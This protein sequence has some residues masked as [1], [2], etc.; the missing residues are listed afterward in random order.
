[1]ITGPTGAGKT[2]TFHYLIDLINS[3]RRAKI[4]TIEDPIEYTQ[5]SKRSVI[6]QQE[7]LTDVRDFKSA[8]THVLRQ[9]PDVIGIG[10]MRDPETIFTA[11]VAAETGHLV[12]ATLHTPDTIQVVERIVSAFSEGQHAM[13]RH[14]LANTLQGVIAQQ[15]IPSAIEDKRVLCYEILMGTPAVRANI[16]E[17][18]VHKLYSTI[19]L[20]RKF[21]MMTMDQNLLELYQQGEISYDSAVS[22]AKYPEAV[23]KRTE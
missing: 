17:N 4:I 15:L 13:V 12:I 23:K 7:V 2:T 14:M 5:V 22:M 8:L 19:Q 9:D 10:E 3:E 6:I 20:G 11:L 16:R 18:E 1:I 21:Q